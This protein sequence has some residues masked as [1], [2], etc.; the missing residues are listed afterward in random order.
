MAYAFLIG[1]DIIQIGIT[2]EDSIQ[3]II[4]WVGFTNQ[5]QHTNIFDDYIRS[6]DD[7]RMFDE[8]YMNNMARDF[9][10]RCLYVGSTNMIHV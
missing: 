5:A 1:N 6:W 4:H 10:G 9:A 8:K 3:Q 2:E 7:I